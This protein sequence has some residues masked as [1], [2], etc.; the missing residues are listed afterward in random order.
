[1]HPKSELDVDVGVKVKVCGERLGKELAMGKRIRL[2]KLPIFVLV[3]V[4]TQYVLTAREKSCVI[5]CDN[6]D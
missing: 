1:M 4:C 2:A 6:V 3:L 5:I